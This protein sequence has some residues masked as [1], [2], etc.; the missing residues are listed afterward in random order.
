MGS[1]HIFKIFPQDKHCFLWASLFFSVRTGFHT[2]HP[3]KPHA[4][5]WAG[6]DDEMINYEVY[7]LILTPKINF[8]SFNWFLLMEH[9]AAVLG[10]DVL[11]ASSP[12]TQGTCVPMEATAGQAGITEMSPT[13]IPG[14]CPT[15]SLKAPQ[16]PS[17][18]G[19]IL[20]WDELV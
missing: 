20:P 14:L 4:G 9:L 10:T 17:R 12:W 6:P 19:N 11:S 5:C 13:R 3:L 8:R 15:H 2:S 7:W 16:G 18:C 1:L